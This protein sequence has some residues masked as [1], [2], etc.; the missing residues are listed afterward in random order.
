MPDY[1]TP[2]AFPPGSYSIEQMLLAFSNCDTAVTICPM[3][4]GLAIRMLLGTPLDV[5]S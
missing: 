2:G 5:H 1:S 4:K 3:A